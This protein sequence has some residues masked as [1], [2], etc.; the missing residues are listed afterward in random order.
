VTDA[1]FSDTNHADIDSFHPT[2]SMKS[3]ID[4]NSIT[5]TSKIHHLHASVVE[6]CIFVQKLLQGSPLVPVAFVL[7]FLHYSAATKAVMQAKGSSSA[8]KGITHPMA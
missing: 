8:R 7:G 2:K 3:S 1:S 5:T 6:L 4:K